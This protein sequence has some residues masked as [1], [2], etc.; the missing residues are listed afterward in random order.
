MRDPNRIDYVLGLLR[1]VWETI[2][3]LRFC[4]LMEILKNYMGVDDLFYIEDDKF[5][6][7]IIDYFD[8]DEKW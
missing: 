5:A 6:Q 2:P 3:D 4:Q 8:L 7:C 1:K